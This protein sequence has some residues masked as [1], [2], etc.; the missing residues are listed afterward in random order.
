MIAG[1][2]EAFEREC[3]ATGRALRRMPADLRQALS[4]QVQPRVAVPLAA[5]VANTFRGPWADRL[6]AQTKARKLAD[7]TIVV[8]G[9]RK[10][11]RNGASARQLVYG[12]EWGGGKRVTTVNR[13]RY[14]TTTG[15]AGRYQIKAGSKRRGRIAAGERGAGGR[16]IYKLRSTQQFRTPHPSI[17]P[18]IRA[19][20]GWV[21]DQ[22]ALIVDEVLEEVNHG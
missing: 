19:E 17:F 10:V 3:K 16:T 8:G 18:T 15:G 7:P 5:K 11:V 1:D 22:F 4:T 9:A 12:N 2:L 14:A 20:G 13:E 21:L 6:A